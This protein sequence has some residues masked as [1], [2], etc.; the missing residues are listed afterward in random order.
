MRKQKFPIWMQFGAC[1]AFMAS[2][3]T[4]GRRG[5]GWGGSGAPGKPSTVV[6]MLSPPLLFR[7]PNQNHSALPSFGF[8]IRVTRQ[9]LSPASGIISP[10]PK[11]APLREAVSRPTRHLAERIQLPAWVGDV[12]QLRRV[13]LR[14]AWDGGG[15]VVGGDRSEPGSQ[16]AV[17]RVAL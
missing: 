9:C 7:G 1:G 3:L 14:R 17:N 11:Q 12:A 5:A 8:H 13:A 4:T 15:G 16:F 6:E 2:S 10:S